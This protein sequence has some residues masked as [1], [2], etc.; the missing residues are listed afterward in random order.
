MF[1]KIKQ[2][3][4]GFPEWCKTEQDDKLCA[5]RAIIVGL[6]YI[7]QDNYPSVSDSRSGYQ[8]RMALKLAFDCNLNINMPIGF[9][10]L[11]KVE[12]FIKDYQIIVINGD[13]M[14]E[15][16]YVSPFKDKKIVLY[17][18]EGH[19]DFVKS[20]PAFFNKRY[21]CFTCFNGYSVF[22]KHP[23]NEVCKK[24]KQRD[25][26]LEEKNQIFCNF[27][28]V[29]CFSNDC[30]INHRMKVCG[31]IPKCV[32]C[33]AFKIKSHVCSGK[34]C[35]YCKTEVDFDHKC[36]ITNEIPATK[37]KPNKGFIFF[38]YAAM[39]SGNHKMVMSALKKYVFLALMEK[40]V[41][42]CVENLHGK[43]TKNFVIGFFRI[44]TI[45][46]LQSHII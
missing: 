32:S 22:E 4:S 3:N 30:L 42:Q 18:K 38:D 19:Y 24:C 14:N 20:I 43:Q 44:Q 28:G 12:E 9:N 6:A 13:S 27:C 15:F 31:N 25:C 23:C 21:F 17:L 8:K 7:N 46:S 33:G 26:G 40:N 34:W 1:L 36:F 41:N 2:E 16:D 35:C 10:E 45:T 29:Y 11:E 39:Q 37:K 5:L